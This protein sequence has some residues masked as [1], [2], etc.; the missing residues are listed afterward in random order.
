[1][2]RPITSYPMTDLHH[3]GIVVPDLAEA[4]ADAARRYGLDMRVLP[5][6]PFSCRIDGCD[7]APV[8]QVALSIEGP[9]YLELL[10]EVP[11]SSIWRPAPGVHHIGFMVE[12]LA[13]AAAELAACGSPIV[14][15][16]VRDGT[17]PVGATYH[18][19]PF[20]HIVELMEPATVRRL[21][22]RSAAAPSMRVDE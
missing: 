6:G 19:D 21:A 2:P 9:P 13:V 14:M 15:G 5:P 1:M 11:G 16:G 7:V 12:E 10:A 3:I 8:T 18:R 22:A 20:G 4:A 17:Y